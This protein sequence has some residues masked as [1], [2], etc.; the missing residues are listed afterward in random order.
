MIVNAACALMVMP[1]ETLGPALSARLDISSVPVTDA[2]MDNAWL[3]VPAVI[4]I[5]KSIYPAPR[6]VFDV[7]EFA[8]TPATSPLNV[9]VTVCAFAFVAGLF[10]NDTR[11]TKVVPATYVPLPV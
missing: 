9:A 8:V 5:K 10:V 11:K 4:V 2:V 6:I 1:K 7:D 3:A